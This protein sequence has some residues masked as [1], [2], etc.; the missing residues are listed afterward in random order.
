MIGMIRKATEEDI[1]GI[2]EL[3]L[4]S[5]G[6][7]WGEAGIEPD[8]DS[9]RSFTESRIN[10]DRMILF[11]DERG[12]LGF[13]HSLGY[14]DI[15]TDTRVREIVSVVVHPDHFGQGIGGL[16]IEDEYTHC[17]REGVRLLKLEVLSSNR[18][19][20]SFYERHGFTEAKKIMLRDV[21][22]GGDL[23]R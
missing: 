10:Q 7:V 1:P 23:E 21:G 18:R 20:I 13:L 11:Q 15:V 22:S 17:K 16:L 8:R 6:P 12:I 3:E 5:L 14:T 19:G 9:L 4:L 2:L